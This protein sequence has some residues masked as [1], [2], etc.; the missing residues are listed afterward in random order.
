MQHLAS[1]RQL[2]CHR[3]RHT[4]SK[5]TLAICAYNGERNR[6]SVWKL[7]QQ[8][9]GVGP[10]SN[11]QVV[12]RWSNSVLS[13]TL[14]MTLSGLW[15]YTCEVYLRQHCLAQQAA[16]PWILRLQCPTLLM[17]HVCRQACIVA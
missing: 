10:L 1:S 5:K 9:S 11:F 15:R 12:S 7:S 8:V 2:A 4:S 13:D 3:T 17:L 6:K 14:E 16:A